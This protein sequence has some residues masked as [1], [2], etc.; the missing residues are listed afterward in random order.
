MEKNVGLG[1]QIGGIGLGKV[2]NDNSDAILP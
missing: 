2:G 1:R